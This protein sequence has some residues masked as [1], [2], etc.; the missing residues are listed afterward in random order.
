[1]LSQIKGGVVGKNKKSPNVKKATGIKTDNI[2]LVITN[3]DQ[4]F[5]TYKTM[6]T[7]RITSDNS[8][9]I[10]FPMLKGIDPKLHDEK[11]ILTDVVSTSEQILYKDNFE[12]QIKS[13]NL[14]NKLNE[15]GI[16]IRVYGMFVVVVFDNNN[17]DK[18]IKIDNVSNDKIDT[19]WHTQLQKHF[20]EHNTELYC[21]RFVQRCNVTS[22]L[23]RDNDNDNVSVEDKEKFV[24]FVNSC[25]VTTS[26]PVSEETK[27]P[28]VIKTYVLVTDLKESNFC[29]I[30]DNIKLLD[31]DTI[32][33]LEV[34]ITEKQC[35]SY[36]VIAWLSLFFAHKSDFYSEISRIAEKQWYSL[37]GFQ[38]CLN[39]I[40]NTHEYISFLPLL[41]HLITYT[42]IF[43]LDSNDEKRKKFLKLIETDSRLVAVLLI[44]MFCY[45]FFDVTKHSDKKET[46]FLKLQEICERVFEIKSI[47]RM[48]EYFTEDY[49]GSKFDELGSVITSLLTEE[50]IQ[51]KPY[52]N[53]VSRSNRSGKRIVTKS[54]YPGATGRN[55]LRAAS[56]VASI[57]RRF[58]QSKS[59]DS[60]G[61]SPKTRKKK[62]RKNK[63][64]TH[65]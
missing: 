26:T 11:N 3:K 22:I 41:S 43:D 23:G 16:S 24:A 60:K 57:A 2:G 15:M 19:F 62:F 38:H 51:F 42:S 4:E 44:Y 20:V 59:S 7:V 50:E 65:L 8:K 45:I 1:M 40:K 14:Q 63:L 39:V 28:H 48:S 61:G 31:V 13:F 18:L 53:S 52:D 6:S 21:V 49:I 29:K 35:K 55:P 17:D 33:T 64:E 9:T 5:G 58:R 46:I 32:N 47:D 37:T 36:Y 25:I 30:G 34:K 56:R 10:K 54:A 12:N 27:S